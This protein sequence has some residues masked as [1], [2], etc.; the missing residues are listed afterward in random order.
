MDAKESCGL[1]GIW[2]DDNAVRDTYLGLYSLQ[3]RG[4]ESAGIAS[5]Q[6]N[7]I[8][9]HKGMGLVQEVFR[10]ENLERL[11]SRVAIGHVRYSTTGSSNILNA[12]PL[13]VD[14]PMSMLAIAHNGNLINS[15][16]IR[17][18]LERQGQ[19]FPLFH[20]STDTEIILYLIARHPRDR[21]KRAI[22]KTC[23]MIKG[24]Y[25]LLVLTPDCLIAIR[26]PN[27]FRP[28]CIGKLN[29][30]YAVSSETCA[31]DIIGA[32][33]VREV[34]PGEVVYISDKGLDSDRFTPRNQCKPSFC[35]FEHVYFARPD[36]Y[37]NKD[38]VQVLRTK[39]GE[40]LAKEYPVKADIV[41]SIPD[42][43]N[44]A[45]L[46]FSKKSKIPYEICFIR[47]HYVGRTFI[48]PADNQR[49]IAVRIK[50][51]V[52]KEVVKGKRVV[53]V[54][55]SIVRGTTVKSRIKLLK[56]T[57]AKEVHLRIS[58]PPIKYPC[59][60]GIDF[61]NKKELI[62]AN[63]TIEEI[64]KFLG[65]DS[66]GYLSLDWMLKCASNKKDS[67]CTAC[68]SGKYP[69]APDTQFEKHILE[70]WNK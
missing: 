56:E 54:D 48:Q 69:V 10:A 50:L 5:I 30:A 7:K 33:H 45:A 38:A 60:Y 70:K 65:A 63:H 67:Y 26:D 6:N 51:S 11:K 14:S 1:F 36:S 68:W 40:Q 18:E 37:L 58:C 12:Q 20:T 47:N 16:A 64:K 27:G 31:F 52:V 49:Q 66:L 25:S 3:H 62:A 23:N 55:D 8:I 28:L 57:G 43:G 42:S 9:Y 61:P 17:T 21:L 15:H 44:A 59:Y 39:L 24:A 29:Q 34:E 13:V 53:V 41:T 4:Q 46:G 32:K 22:R 35:M 19:F 2:G